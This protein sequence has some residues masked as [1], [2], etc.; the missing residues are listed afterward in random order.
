MD[1]TKSFL[2]VL[3]AINDFLWNQ[4]IKIKERIAKEQDTQQAFTHSNMFY[5]K[6]VTNFFY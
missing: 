1:E 2:P 5:D 6:V 4:E 3:E